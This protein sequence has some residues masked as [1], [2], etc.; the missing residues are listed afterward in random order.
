MKCIICDTDTEY[1]FKGSSMCIN[2]I[3]EFFHEYYIVPVGRWDTADNLGNL[4]KKVSKSK[5]KKNNKMNEEA[6]YELLSNLVITLD[7][8]DLLSEYERAHYTNFLEMI[9]QSIVKKGNKM[10]ELNEEQE[11]EFNKQLEKYGKNLDTPIDQKILKAL[12]IKKRFCPKCKEFTE[13]IPLDLPFE[14]PL[15]TRKTYEYYQCKKCKENFF[16]VSNIDKLWE[17]AKKYYQSDK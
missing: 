11:K 1:T 8:N 10:V 14:D 2:C 4:R 15:L 9:K 6:V 16:V 13:I 17:E 7:N 12:G 5:Q 3:K